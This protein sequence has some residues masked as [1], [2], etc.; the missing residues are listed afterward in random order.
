MARYLVFDIDWETDGEKVKLPKKV[1]VELSEEENPSLEIANI[2]SD[3]FGFLVN[4]FEFERQ[5]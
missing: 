2:L 4:G 1:K 3:N 5:K